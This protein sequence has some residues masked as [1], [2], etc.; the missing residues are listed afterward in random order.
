MIAATTKYAI[1][2]YSK[3]LN[4]RTTT[5]VYKYSSYSYKVEKGKTTATSYITSDYTTTTTIYKIIN[6]NSSKQTATRSFQ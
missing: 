1:R 2:D 4:Y 5:K 3:D 6:L